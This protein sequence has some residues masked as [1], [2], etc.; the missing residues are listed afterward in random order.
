[1][2]A[3]ISTIFAKHFS[4]IWQI[5]QGVVYNAS[6]PI[7]RRRRG[8]TDVRLGSAGLSY[9][10]ACRPTQHCREDNIF[11]RSQQYIFTY[12]QEYEH[13]DLFARVHIYASKRYECV[14]AIYSIS[15]ST[16][17][18]SS[19]VY[20]ARRPYFW[21]LKYVRAYASTR[22]F[23]ANARMS[24]SPALIYT[25]HATQL[26]HSASFYGR[27][28]QKKVFSFFAFKFILNKGED[29]SWTQEE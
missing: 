14:H 18:C 2:P 11:L 4:Y 29:T 17:L 3:N 6:K 8:K 19:C 1:M 20:L 10:K 15:S 22:L 7:W 16:N 13:A 21:Q 23:L 5:F 27:H 24:L 28:K 9:I 12:I 25:K 26:L